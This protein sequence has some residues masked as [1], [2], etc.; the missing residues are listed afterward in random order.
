MHCV[1]SIKML[2]LGG[3]RRKHHWKQRKISETLSFMML[4][5]LLVVHREQLGDSA[6]VAPPSEATRLFW[7]WRDS[8]RQR[9]SCGSDAT[10]QSDNEPLLGF[11][12]PAS[13]KKV[14]VEGT[15]AAP[16][17]VRY[18]VAKEYRYEIDHNSNGCSGM[19]TLTRVCS[20]SREIFLDTQ[21]SYVLVLS[22][23]MVLEAFH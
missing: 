19:N 1:A 21:L 3:N 10:L 11:W 2:S 6:F 4:L 22:L 7:G 20:C 5:V 14:A 18:R 8:E 12:V 13:A 9:V 15:Q 17:Q 16:F 23:L